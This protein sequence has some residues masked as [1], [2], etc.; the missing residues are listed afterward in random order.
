MHV[1]TLV[2]RRGRRDVA[3]YLSKIAPV[4]LAHRLALVVHG[5]LVFIGLLRAELRRP[6]VEAFFKCLSMDDPEGGV[7]L[8]C[9]PEIGFCGG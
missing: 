4:I 6:V 1:R 5:V 7:D 9:I 3:F 2:M 8:Q